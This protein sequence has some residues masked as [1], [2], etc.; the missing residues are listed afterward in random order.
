[1]KF[2]SFITISWCLIW[3]AECRPSPVASIRNLDIAQRA[4]DTFNAHDWEAHA[5]LF[6]D[7]CTYLDPSYG[8]HPVRK[9]RAEK[10]QKYRELEQ[11]AP[12]IRDSITG[13][14]AIG[15][16][17]VVQFISMGTEQTTNGP[18]RWELPICTIFTIDDGR[19]VRD[20]TY[21]DRSN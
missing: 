20:D 12:D 17:V 19:I 21:Y 9:T 15:D 11:Y 1:M 18:N 14:L 7:P 2:L 3:L 16:K 5:N 10:I 4:F 6:S 13:L 8:E